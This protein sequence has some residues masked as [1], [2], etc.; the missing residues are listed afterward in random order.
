VALFLFV[1]SHTAALADIPQG[2]WLL[3]GKVVVQIFD[4]AS[5]MCG[6]I[7]WLKVPRYPQGQLDRDKSNPNPTLRNRQL[8]GLTIIWNLQRASPD[9]WKDG[10]FY[11]PDDGKTYRVAARFESSDTIIARIYLGVPL[12]GETKTLRRVPHGTSAG[13]C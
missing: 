3:D 1:T 13:W 6:R 9:R 10:W 8:C 5:K 7:L 4:C 11:N 12:F 2:E